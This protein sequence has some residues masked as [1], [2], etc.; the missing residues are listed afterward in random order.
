MVLAESTEFAPA[1]T[2]SHIY[3]DLTQ[4]NSGVV[5]FTSDDAGGGGSEN[6]RFIAPFVDCQKIFAILPVEGMPLQA[7]SSTFSS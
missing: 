2:R 7:L 5:V 1:G 3:P 4:Y 6:T